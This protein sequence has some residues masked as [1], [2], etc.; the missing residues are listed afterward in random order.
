MR[1][2]AGWPAA[3]ARVLGAM[4]VAV[5]AVVLLVVLLGGML[6]VPVFGLGVPIVA[7]GLRATRRLTAACR[8]VAGPVL[9]TR[10]V[11]VYTGEPG[12][13]WRELRAGL[14]DRQTVR[15]V[16]WL[17]AHGAVGLIAIGGLAMM[18]ETVRISVTG[19]AGWVAI[20][21]VPVLFVVAVLF[22]MVPWADRGFVLLAGE[23]LASSEERL[24]LR[25]EAL[26]R[27]RAATVDAQAAELRRIERDLHD[28][29]QA[30]LAALGMT[31]GL[32]AQVVH[33]DPRQ[34]AE[35]IDEARAEAGTALA[36]LRDL[37]RGIHPPVLAD[38]G[39]PG[40]LAAA[41]LLCPVPVEVDVALAGRPEPPVESAVYFAV[42]ETLV[43]VGR[44]AAAT[45]VKLQVG[46]ADEVLTAL[47][48]DDG[49][50]GADPAR[51][52]GLRGIADRLAAFDGTM[53]V[54]SPPGGPTEISM[55]VPCRLR[56][57]QSS[58]RTT[59]SSGTA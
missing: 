21:T 20:F 9:D 7:G 33:T 4:V 54:I 53:S 51:G 12:R 10:L 30:R 5:V 14:H 1:I 56:S 3:A 16:V 48:V 19:L 6:L 37:V 35:L 22:V 52:T 25:V 15:D 31:L 13:T 50:G 34:A 59:S 24:A 41:A 18:A 40:G 2:V 26:T 58:P 43:N 45:Q 38:R 39:L 23:L 49:V 42:V 28:G 36:E 46:H 29:A 55:E 44:H 27:S 47:V 17:V 57:E 32:A 11:A 8:A